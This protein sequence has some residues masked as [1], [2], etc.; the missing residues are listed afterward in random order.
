MSKKLYVIKI[1]DTIS[2]K[3][4]KNI[5]CPILNKRRHIYGGKESIRYALLRIVLIPS[6]A[7]EAVQM[8]PIKAIVNTLCGGPEVISSILGVTAED[9]FSIPIELINELI[10]SVS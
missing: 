3:K 5:N 1:D 6:I 9:N 7:E 4:T 10:M 8:M 2:R